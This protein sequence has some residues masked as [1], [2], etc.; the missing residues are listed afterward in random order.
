MGAIRQWWWGREDGVYNFG[1]ELAPLITAKTLGR[2]VVWAPRSEA[3]LV[4]IGSVLGLVRGAGSGMAI[5]GAGLMWE[6]SDPPVTDARHLAVRGRLTAERIGFD[7]PMGDPGILAS[8]LTS[9]VPGG[10]IGFMP[11]YVDQETEFSQA[12]TK[13]HGVRFIDANAPVQESLD[14]MRECRFVLSSSLHGCVVADGLGIPNVW[15]EL[16][17]RVAGHGYKFRDYYSVYG[18]EPPQELDPQGWLE[19]S[20]AKVAEW[21]DSYER[22]G[23]EGLK[24][25]LRAAL[26]EHFS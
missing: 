16:S 24:E 14:V 8:D 1:D 18:M 21:S 15:V 3:Q 9:R 26:R 10:S 4:G 20:D 25:P 22:P 23:I 7:G 2:E 19:D 11:H 12:F 6:G 13:V 5:W 17:D